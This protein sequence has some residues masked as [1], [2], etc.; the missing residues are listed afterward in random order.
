MRLWIA[1]AVITALGVAA[2][3]TVTPPAARAT[4][5]VATVTIRH[6]VATIYGALATEV[7][8]GDPMPLSE[9]SDLVVVA[10]AT[11]ADGGSCEIDVNGASVAYA[12]APA[13]AA[14]AC[15]WD[16]RAR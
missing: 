11:T 2:Q 7:V 4:P 9:V 14:V 12:S 6:A 5:A 3:V 15:V 10:I 8:I 13:G 1:L 16:R